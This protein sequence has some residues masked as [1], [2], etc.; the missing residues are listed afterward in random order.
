M[1]SAPW[2]LELIWIHMRWRPG[3]NRACF[4]WGPR[5]FCLKN[6]WSQNKFVG[7]NAASLW[8]Q[9]IIYQI[10]LLTRFFKATTTTHQPPNQATNQ[11][12]SFCGACHNNALKALRSPTLWAWAKASKDGGSTVDGW[13][14]VGYLGCLFC[15]EIPG[16]NLGDFPPTAG[17]WK[18]PSLEKENH[19]NQT[20]IFWVPC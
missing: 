18:S 6:P 1:S 4:R 9:Q 2:L 15:R 3:C 11:G 19:L 5:E 20:F 12:T 16:G 13:V 7:Q 17:T 10:L 14:E 8:N